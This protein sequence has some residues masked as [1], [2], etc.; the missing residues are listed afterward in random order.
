MNDV[1]GIQMRLSRS[2]RGKERA[3]FVAEVGTKTYTHLCLYEGGDGQ[4]YVNFL[5]QYRLSKEQKIDIRLCAVREYER[6]TF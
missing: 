3:T 1:I 4:L 5:P 6:M 2:R